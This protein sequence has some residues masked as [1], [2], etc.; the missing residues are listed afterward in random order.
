MHAQGFDRA[1]APRYRAAGHA[2]LAGRLHVRG[3]VADIDRFIPGDIGLSHQPLNPRLLAE[4]G[5]SA[6]D[7]ADQ[8]RDVRPKDAIDVLAR[9]GRHDGQAHAV[10]GKVA[11]RFAHALEERNS[12]GVL[13]HHRD[14][15]LRYQGKLPC[16]QADMAHQLPGGQLPQRLR[17]AGLD[18]PE[19]MRVREQVEY[20]GE[21]GKRVGKRAVEIE[22]GE[23]VFH[24]FGLSG[25]VIVRQKGRR[26]G[27]DSFRSFA[28]AGP[29]AAIAAIA[30]MPMISI[31]A[32][33]VE[34]KAKHVVRPLPHGASQATPVSLPRQKAC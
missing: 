34:Y 28:G 2:R 18:P 25:S 8:L 23:T 31:T 20:A 16:R 27:V 13:L 32:L 11:Q 1:V 10:V 12:G 30:A 33:V 21:E 24:G 26:M 9:V 5:H 4:D 17:F 19:I 22:D 7:M 3:L 14:E 6:F 15:A 29:G